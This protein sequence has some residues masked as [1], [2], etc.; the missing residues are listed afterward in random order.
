MSGKLILFFWVLGSTAYVAEL[1]LFGG[2]FYFVAGVLEIISLYKSTLD[3]LVQ[4]H[5]LVCKLQASFSSVNFADK[6]TVP[7]VL[8]DEGTVGSN[9]SEL[10]S[11]Y[12]VDN[13]S[14]MM[15]RRR[16]KRS[17]TGPNIIC[18][19]EDVEDHGHRVRH[20]RSLTCPHDLFQSSSAGTS[21]T[22]PLTDIET[23]ESINSDSPAESTEISQT[24]LGK[25]I[26]V[27]A[28]P[29]SNKSLNC[30]DAFKSLSSNSSF[31]ESFRLIRSLS[32]SNVINI[33]QLPSE[34]M[35]EDFRH[36]AFWK[37]FKSPT[38]YIAAIFT[39]GG[40]M[41]TIG[42]CKLLS[43]SVRQNLYLAGSTLF[44]CGGTLILFRVKINASDEWNLLQESRLALHA[45]L[46]DGGDKV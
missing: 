43:Q 27:K 33:H 19:M 2:L 45:L 36:M 3:E 28:K 12:D 13:S 8:D 11:N 39:L 20:R 37:Q 1:W 14:L 41:F 9:L 46:S 44:M 5:K 34:K 15:I 24:F 4:N 31:D 40:L 32:Q 25:D 18:I 10:G 38:F 22:E 16:H 7:R 42:A 29:K 6:E 17:G 35:M 26:I 23:T 30:Y 21:Q